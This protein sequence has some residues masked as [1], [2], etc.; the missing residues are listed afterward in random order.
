MVGS[1]AER[2]EAADDGEASAPNADGAV[3]LRLGPLLPV[4]DAEW[5]RRGLRSRAATIRALLAE[6]LEDITNA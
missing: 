4:I 1:S 6:A 5:H 2:I 3:L